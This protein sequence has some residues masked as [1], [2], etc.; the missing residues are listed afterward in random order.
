[1]TPERMWSGTMT[2]R[3][4]AGEDEVVYSGTPV[5]GLAGRPAPEDQR[6]YGWLVRGSWRTE[7]E[8]AWSFIKQPVMRH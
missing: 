1:M 2:Y 5:I 6:R 8:L 3:V 7:S 4:R